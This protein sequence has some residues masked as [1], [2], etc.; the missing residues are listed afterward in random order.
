MSCF[1]T[2]ALENSV[3]ASNDPNFKRT[4]EIARYNY[5]RLIQDPNLINEFIQL[6]S[7]HLTF[8]LN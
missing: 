4:Q 3:R 8:F 5:Q 2:V 1:K 7:D 6:C